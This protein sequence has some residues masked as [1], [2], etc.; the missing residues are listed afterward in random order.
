M[1]LH[2]AEVELLRQRQNVAGD[3]SGQQ[4]HQ[5]QRG[6]CHGLN[7]VWVTA[8]LEVELGEI[9]LLAQPRCVRR[10]AGRGAEDLQA[11]GDAGR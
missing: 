1:I 8:E 10:V 9:G 3:L 6:P 2:A 7:S 4:T 11:L 5:R